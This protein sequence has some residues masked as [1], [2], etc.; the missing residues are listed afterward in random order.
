MRARRL[1]FKRA[2]LPLEAFC[3][4]EQLIWLDLLEFEATL[5][6]GSS[7]FAILTCSLFILLLYIGAHR[8]AAA[9]C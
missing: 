7:Q 8:A 2:L 5:L 1:L 6:T 3:V 9:L 4:N